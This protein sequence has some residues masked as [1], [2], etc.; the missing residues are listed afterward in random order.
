MKNEY[1]KSMG[2]KNQQLLR[3]WLTAKDIVSTNWE[4][5]EERNERLKTIFSKINETLPIQYTGDIAHDVESA[6]KSIRTNDLLLKMNNNGR[7]IE[8]VYYTWMQGYI[9]EKVFVP[10]ICD[11]LMLNQ[12]KS[13][14]LVTGFLYRIFLWFKR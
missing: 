2:F 8:D 6:Y 5:V 3:K 9:C 13:L 11:R 14:G 1:L 10:F 12:G 4:L 7:S